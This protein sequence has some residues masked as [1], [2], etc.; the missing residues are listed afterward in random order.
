MA[1]GANLA[2]AYR[3]AQIQS[4]LRSNAS[5]TNHADYAQTQ[6][7][8]E[9]DGKSLPC[10]NLCAPD[11]EDTSVVPPEL[12]KVDKCK[13]SV[14]GAEEWRKCVPIARIDSLRQIVANRRVAQGQILSE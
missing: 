6:Y 14:N 7:A 12:A 9:K 11:P 2:A 1:N 4:K 3:F 10:I 5:P 8:E 13:V